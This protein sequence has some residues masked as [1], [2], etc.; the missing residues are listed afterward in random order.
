MSAFPDYDRY[1]ALGL[2]A[3]VRGGEVRP[4]ELLEEAL[5]RA[6]ALNPEL[7]AIIY[8]M[9]EEARAT[10]RR[11]LPDGPFAG[12]PFLLKDLL[13]AY[14]G[15]PLSSGSAALRGFVPE[16]DA[17]LVARYKAAGLVIFG[18]TNTPEF[19][20]MGITEPDA[21]GPT[22][23]PW[24]LERSPGGSS[25]GSAAAVAAGLAPLASAN[26]SGGSIRIPAAW[27]GLFGLKPSRGRVPVDPE[28]STG[29]GALVDLGLS[30]SVRDSAA[31]LDA[32]R[33]PAPGAPYAA[34]EPEEPYLRAIERPPRPLR[35]AFSARSP[36][37]GPVHPEC[38]RALEEALRLLED[39]G[40]EVEEAGPEIDGPAVARAYL[41]MYFGQTSA[42][43]DELAETMGRGPVWSGTEPETRALAAI[44]RSLR[45]PGYARQRR[46]WERFAHAM[47]AFHERFDL[48]CTPTTATPPVRTGEL[49]TR[50]W[51]RAALELASA[52]RMGRAL[53]AAG[54]FERIAETNLSRVPFTQL[55]NLTGQPAMSVPLHWTAGGLPVGVHFMAPYGD[56]ATLLRLAAQLEVARPWFLRRPPLVAREAEAE[57]PGQ[58]DARKI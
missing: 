35:I 51:E 19:G 24:D 45:A 31:L 22:R 3:L 18:K 33:G 23:N 16:R 47:G 27:C 38:V 28:E 56:E 6:A 12:V 7:N 11:G 36:L 26:D 39:L 8:D 44:G 34:P 37:G 46:R 42:T 20:L 2:A 41:T 29:E 15:V 40:H 4:E 9:A 30:R 1:D 57:A 55:A 52:L 48:Y 54:I 58:A 25:G 10:I 49:K 21:F 50:G 53:L 17:A 14:A 32:V 43:L 5:H 13:Q